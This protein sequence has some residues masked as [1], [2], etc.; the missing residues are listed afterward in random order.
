MRQRCSSTNPSRRTASCPGRRRYGHGAPR[1]TPEFLPEERWRENTAYLR[2]VDFFN[3]GWW[4]EAHEAWEELWHVVEGKD[5]RQHKLLK[6]LIQLAACALNRERGVGGGAD[7]LLASATAAL[8]ELV[9]TP[10]LLGVD[11]NAMRQAAQSLL[12]ANV[13]QVNGFY[14]PLREAREA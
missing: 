7:R 14:V 4:W 1:P 11:L 8:D 12:A 13:P 5:E 10:T 3:R 9:A 6:A 2:G